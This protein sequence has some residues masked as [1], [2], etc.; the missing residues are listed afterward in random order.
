VPG[1]DSAPQA[2]SRVSNINFVISILGEGYKYPIKIVEGR[3]VLSHF[4]FKSKVLP[5]PFTD[6]SAWVEFCTS[7]PQQDVKIYFDI[8]T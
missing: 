1:W 4:G 8:W 5:G 2:R 3:K 7:R 6:L